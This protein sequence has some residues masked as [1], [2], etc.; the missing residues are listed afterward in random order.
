[1]NRT[2]GHFGGA[3]T[4]TGTLVC[5]FV[6]TLPPR[7]AAAQSEP[8]S[9]DI[10]G[11]SPISDGTG[12]PPSLAL[13][14]TNLPDGQKSA[15]NTLSPN[16][17]IT[18]DGSTGSAHGTFA[19]Q[20]PHARGDAQP[21]L[22]LTYDSSVQA[23][24]FAGAGWS[25]PMPS[26]VRRGAAGMPLFTDDVFSA[27]PAEL[28][29]PTATFD[30]YLADGQV[31]VPICIV[32]QCGGVTLPGEVLPASLAGTSLSGFM[33]FRREVD[34]GAR[35]FFAPNGQTWLKQTKAG[36]VTQFG[37]PLDAGS[38]D[39]SLDDGID[40]PAGATNFASSV[41][42]AN[43]VYRWEIVRESDANGNTVYY[44]WTTNGSLAPGST[45]PGLQYL[46]DVYDTL[47][48]GQPVAPASF[49][50]HVH[51][52]WQLS[53]PIAQPVQ[54]TSPIWRAVPVA[55]IANVDVTGA[56]WSSAARALVRRYDLA[57]QVN[58]Y[59]TLNRLSTIT[60]EG[61]CL[62]SS[63]SALAP[64]PE[65]TNGLVPNPTSCAGDART[66]RQLMQLTYYADTLPGASGPSVSPVSQVFA[67]PNLGGNLSVDA[68]QSVVS[69]TANI[70][71]VNGDGAGDLVAGPGPFSV[72]SFSGS[73][74]TVTPPS[75]PS[76]TP[77]S[78]SPEYAVL[79][80]SDAGAGDAGAADGG[81]SGPPTFL[82]QA[83]CGGNSGSGS[84]GFTGNGVIENLG[85]LS[86]QLGAGT[87]ASAGVEVS[88]GQIGSGDQTFYHGQYPAMF[89][90]WLSNGQ[91]NWITENLQGNWN[92]YTSA[93]GAISGS[94]LLVGVC[95][96]DPLCDRG[97]G[98]DVDGDGLLDQWGAGSNTY[99]SQ[100]THGGEISP[101][102]LTPPPW[103]GWSPIDF[104]DYA[105]Q[106]PGWLTLH[107][108][109]PG[110]TCMA[111]L[112]NSWPPIQQAE[113]MNACPADPSQF[114]RSM[115][116]M[117]GDGLPD[118]VAGFIDGYGQTHL[119][120]WLNQGDGTMGP[121]S[122]SFV[123]SDGLDGNICESGILPNGRS[124][125]YTCTLDFEL[126]RLADM[127]GDG[128]A[129]IVK[130]INGPLTVCI[131]NSP[132][133]SPPSYACVS[134]P[135][136]PLQ[137]PY[138]IDPGRT[139]FNIADIDGTGVPRAIVSRYIDQTGYSD[140]GDTDF[141]AASVVPGTSSS[142]GAIPAQPYPG[143]LQG[144]TLLGGARQS[145][146]YAPI[147]S[148]SGNA[149]PVSGWV[150]TSLQ[151]TNG[152]PL[153][154]LQAT[155]STVNYNYANPIYDPRDKQFVGFQSVTQSATGAPGSPGQV[156]A[157]T[158]ATAACGPS[159]GT[160]CIHQ[161][162][163]GWFR[164]IRGLPLAINVADTK[165]T[166]LQT[167]VSSY[168]EHEPYVGLDGRV[169]RRLPVYKQ[170]TYDWDPTAQSASTV[171]P[172]SFVH[173][174]ASPYEAYSLGVINTVQV[175][176][177]GSVRVQQRDEDDFGNLQDTIDFGQPG[178]DVPIRTSLQWSLPS[179]DTTG[180]NYRVTTR[181][182]G[183]TDASGSNLQAP[184][185]R[186]YGYSYTS[187]GQLLT[188]T[189]SLPN[190]PAPM[191][192]PNFAAG[193][194]PDATTGSQVCMVGCTS[195]NVTGVQY[196]RYGNSITVPRANN[197]CSATV[198]DPLFAQFPQTT[199]TYASGC[200]S[201]SPAPMQTV[202][203]Y[204]RGLE[205]VTESTAPFSGVVP[206]TTL[207]QYD[208]FGRV[209]QVDQ[210]MAQMA[211]MV[212]TVNPAL[213]VQYSD[214][215]VPRQVVSS[216][217]DGPSTS[218]VYNL[219]YQFLDGWGDTLATF[220]Q[221][222]S[223]V[224]AVSGVHTR[225]PNGPTSQAWPP[226]VAA[227]SPPTF[228]LSPLNAAT[229]GSPS[230]ATS[231]YDGEGRVVTRTDFNGFPT[232]YAYHF[233]GGIP[234]ASGIFGAA[235]SVTTQDPEQ[236]PPSNAPPG[237]HHVDSFTTRY[238]DG[239]GRATQSD[240]HWNSTA[241]GGGDLITVTSL[242]ASG[243][244]LA[245]TQ[246]FPG[247]LYSRSMTYDGVG[248]RVSQT[249]PNVG[250]STYA[251][252]DSGDLVGTM[253]ARGCGEV[254]YHDGLGRLIAEDYSPCSSSDAPAYSAPNLRTG[255]GTE[256]FYAYDGYGNLATL[257]DR[258]ERSTFKYDGRSRATWAIRQFATPTG[259]AALASRYAP[260]SFSKAFLQ[261][262]ESNKV[263][264]STTGTDLAALEVGGLSQV[265]VSYA[266]LG[267]L[268]S[269][270][271]SYGALVVSQSTDASGRVT[272]RAYG[273]V[274]STTATARYDF[275]EALVSYGLARVPGPWTAY[276]QGT[277]P[278]P[279]A[280]TVQSVL[281]NLSIARDMVGNPTALTQNT[282]S[283]GVVP[284]EWPPGAAPT[285]SRSLV[286]GD[287]Y[288]LQEVQAQ[289]A[290]SS[291]GSGPDDV[292]VSPYVQSDG[293]L[294][295]TPS[296]VSTGNRA[297]DQKYV[298]NL[299]GNLQL[300]TDDA[301]VFFDRSL[302]NV[303]GVADQLTST[304]T[305]TGY[306]SLTTAYD[307]GGNLESVAIQGGSTYGYTFDELGRLASASRVDPGGAQIREQYSY[308]ANGQRVRI[309]TQNS[310]TGD[311][312]HTLQVFDSLVLRNALFPDAGGNYEHDASTE[313]LY[314]NAGGQS[315]GHA[316]I[317]QASIPS[318]TASPIHVFMPMRDPLGS[319]S[320]VVDHDTSELV[321]AATYQPYGAVES[322]YRPSR[323]DSFREDIRYTTHWD[324]AEVGLVYF[325]ARYYTPN[326]M[327]FIT[328]DPLSIHALKGDLNPYEYANGSPMLYTDPSGMSSFLP[329]GSNSQQQQNLLGQSADENL[330]ASQSWDN[331]DYWSAAVTF[332][333]SVFNFA[334]GSLPS[335]KPT[336][337]SAA[338]L[339]NP[340]AAAPI[341]AGEAAADL[342]TGA[343]ADLGATAAAADLSETAGTTD[344]SA[345]GG[346]GV[347]S[348]AADA[349]RLA[350][351]L[352]Q[353]EAESAFSPAGE[354]SQD[355]I[356]GSRQI[357]APGQLGNPA[358]PQG[359]G[360]FSTQTFQS[361]SGPFQV[362]FYM[363]PSTEEIFYGLDYKAVFNGNQGP[364]YFQPFS[365]ST[366]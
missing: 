2:R 10:T 169:V 23:V 104:N 136:P 26:I 317:A 31:L 36:H 101:F 260:Q 171:Q 195:G 151:A 365:G 35:Y 226:F 327:R 44:T 48:V 286:Y 245:V 278:P 225:Y 108:G 205:K 258:G 60:L 110:V 366:P 342:I 299:R 282:Q 198:Y 123:P 185:A 39:P 19:F 83:G 240:Q 147:R 69:Q 259:G 84:A 235:A 335:F 124:G 161:V 88:V 27:S 117:N 350:M 28:A 130:V 99:L 154:A 197:R 15:L 159:T 215:S 126:V 201:T 285:S 287:D 85:Q 138:G 86:E 364:T 218:P 116:D 219:H 252:N 174:G 301:N 187:L 79:H 320:F 166:Q 20:L 231:T 246:S 316:F 264:E 3:F 290:G 82:S 5:F 22:A 163:Y 142:L 155:T 251:Y 173:L 16:A 62:A 186:S 168:S 75:D 272:Q 80:T 63:G 32:G 236:N 120:T 346:A 68:N 47:G 17:Q 8:D 250:T 202:V 319:T 214:T 248:H 64:V 193:S 228:A 254:L 306:G 345:A 43:A 281:S 207:T 230:P 178:V 42:P 137:N 113:Y 71:D 160:S 360:K 149:I 37:H 336:S 266:P 74:T 106:F 237:L 221:M 6:T 247:G 181:S 52:N 361:P 129:D 66:Q 61:E 112:S 263:L 11:T 170:T 190:E 24:G 14:S 156:R 38:V 261:Y 222:G 354:L 145:V 212:D 257:S 45:L 279:G 59:G 328:P 93:G 314:L 271:S 216:T 118:T 1:M 25:L 323:W 143:L 21:Q 127:N 73:P 339:A 338:G 152:L 298:Y 132:R 239:H 334:L 242:A 267:P 349:P 288:R 162:D 362:H 167:T 326:L 318:A 310:V 188:Q 213:L 204:D 121:P 131:R 100:R 223:G 275:D 333:A 189:A 192:S 262:S 196:D 200:G 164:T 90:D 217:I 295:A 141:V 206:H 125:F 41:N 34:D 256:A 98:V 315:F 308:D 273:D 30:E 65:G 337:A 203:V 50:H 122:T 18:V 4:A 81:D 329:W 209:V 312:L 180:W 53:F 311:T 302:G 95:Q 114:Y 184:P 341:A 211:G 229:N 179:G 54:D 92:A 331:G 175:P 103:G 304:G 227:G 359:F 77:C 355:A 358:V 276:L 165:G 224:W 56:S 13:P 76:Y 57:Y 325:G 91:A 357:I 67:F 233:G 232:T 208:S 109:L 347:A 119:M 270:N 194:P 111:G 70:V 191:G 9:T 55:Q 210:P 148:V 97:R 199:L 291:N 294:Y 269:V 177:T 289:Y 153:S 274:A 128:L 176:A 140:N 150:V 12:G 343:A 265:T 363:N 87:S 144:M 72:Q 234:A 102:S 307:P 135:L 324:D 340:L 353:Q 303:S 344:L 157:T 115:A 330:Q 283:G 292:F 7:W 29:A 146:T 268:S 280:T 182:L 284:E 49:A 321:E 139:S 183:Y 238:S 305:T 244:P 105:Q 300:S 51:V 356:Q 241:S 352:A 107:Q 40:R 78:L 255:D 348:N 332:G 94:P 133:L 309:T 313:H 172:Q 96:T 296:P 58:T 277:A 253:D 249:E 33:Y 351:D 293:A 134:T 297:R 243:E 220:D 158:F 322:D 89:G 46:S